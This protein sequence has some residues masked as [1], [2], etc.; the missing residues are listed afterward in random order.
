MLRMPSESRIVASSNA[1]S[2][3][4]A[5]AVPVAITIAAG[6]QHPRVAMLVSDLDVVRIGEPAVTGEHAHVVAGEL[7]ADDVDL[8]RHHLL[9]R[10]IRSSIVISSLTR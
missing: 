10:Q 8:P 6:L 3:G 2:G 5:G 4:C 1:T 7:V 9:V